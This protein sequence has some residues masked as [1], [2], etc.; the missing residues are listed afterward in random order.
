[1][2]IISV[3]IISY[4]DLMKKKLSK[5]DLKEIEQWK[6]LFKRLYRDPYYKKLLSAM[7]KEYE[8]LLNNEKKVVKW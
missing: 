3:C 4:G 1:M 7:L 2:H 5:K 8:I 6:E